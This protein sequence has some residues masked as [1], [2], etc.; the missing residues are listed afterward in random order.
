MSD[1]SQILIEKEN[2]VISSFP[3]PDEVRHRIVFSYEKDEHMPFLLGWSHGLKEKNLFIC[4]SSIV[5]ENDDNLVIKKIITK[6]NMDIVITLLY[7]NNIFHNGKISYNNEEY[8]I[9]YI[10]MY[11][12]LQIGSFCYDNIGVIKLDYEIGNK[13]FNKN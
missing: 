13:I 7:K 10:N 1:N 9:K 3:K 8:E 4:T 5:S 6:E 12:S 2:F 11:Y